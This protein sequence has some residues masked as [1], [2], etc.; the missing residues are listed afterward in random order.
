MERV[1]GGHLHVLAGLH[2]VDAVE[3]HDK[4]AYEFSIGI[5]TNGRYSVTC[6]ACRSLC[7]CCMSGKVGS[8]MHA[9]G[10]HVKSEALLRTRSSE[11]DGSVDVLAEKRRGIAATAERTGQQHT[12]SEQDT[13]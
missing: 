8:E 6:G 2:V 13:R 4:L 5:S 7:C 10:A 1:E 11:E 9:H 3:Q 12:V